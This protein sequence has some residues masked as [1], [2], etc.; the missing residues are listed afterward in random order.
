MCPVKLFWRQADGNRKYGNS[1][2]EEVWLNSIFGL[3]SNEVFLSGSLAGMSTKE[4]GYLVLHKISS[5]TKQLCLLPCLL[6]KKYFTNKLR[7]IKIRSACK[8]EKSCSKTSQMIQLAGC[9][10]FTNCF[11]KCCWSQSTGLFDTGVDH[12]HSPK[13]KLTIKIKCVELCIGMWLM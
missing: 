6:R 8:L 1:S 5:T 10:N 9:Y 11:R 3:S 7:S 4:K 13:G 2:S 12:W